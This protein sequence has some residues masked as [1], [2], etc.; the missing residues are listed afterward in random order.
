MNNFNIFQDGSGHPNTPT[1]Q[2]SKLNFKWLFSFCLVGLLSISSN[3]VLAQPPNDNLADAIEITTIPYT[4]PG[5][6][7]V[8]MDAA[9]TE[10]NE[11][12]CGST[13]N[14]V[15][16]W[17]YTFTTT[18]SGNLN[19]QAADFDANPSFFG[20]QLYMG[21]YTDAT[22]PLTEEECST[23]TVAALNSA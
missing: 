6:P 18:V 20:A 1:P 23:T 9:T 11:N 13:F 7:D 21:I 19:F 2:Q 8:E 22:H 15:G 5:V 4:S 16:S 3:F 14:P 10:T 17:W 12:V